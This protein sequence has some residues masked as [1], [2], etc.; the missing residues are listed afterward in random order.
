MFLIIVRHCDSI[1]R[2]D[3][4]WSQS[5]WSHS[6]ETV[7]RHF[8]NICSHL[9]RLAPQFIGPP[10]FDNIPPVITNN[11]NY[12]PYFQDCIGAID[13]THIPCI[14]VANLQVAYR[15]RKGFTSQNVLAIVDFDMKFTYIVAG[16]EG[17]VHDARVLRDAMS[18]P[19]FSFPK[20]P[21]D[22][23]FLVDS[24]YVN[25]RGFFAPYRGT[26]YHLR[27]RRKVGGDRKKELFNYRHAS[28]RNAVERTFRIWKSRFRIL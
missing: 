14:I 17:S 15:N 27:D 16:W 24:G 26:N 8:N 5:E 20:P 2:S 7:S 25:R 4:E 9:V 3:Y 11:P 10:D 19:N 6:T 12:F 21:R 23:Y 13:G 18:D 1:R 22:K 28:L